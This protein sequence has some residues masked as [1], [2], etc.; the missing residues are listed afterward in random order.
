MPTMIDFPLLA[1]GELSRAC[2][3]YGLGRFKDVVAFVRSLP[4]GRISDL[5]DL[6]LVL[7]EK[8]GTC[9]SKHAFLAAVAGE[10]GQR[11]SLRLGFYEMNGENT[12]GVGD[13]LKRYGVK[14]I[15]EGH[16]YLEC[17]GTRFDYTRE[18]ASENMNLDV[19]LEEEI[20]P[21]QI[22]SYKTWKH[23]QVLQEWLHNQAILLSFADAWM[24]REECIRAIGST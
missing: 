17:N 12:P 7:A 2:E 20:A 9:S 3:G 11:I 22:G 18:V 15:L 1:S 5:S 13:V 8:R 16:C 23:R 10:L 21:S 19:I 4:Y 6:S 24:I 14:A